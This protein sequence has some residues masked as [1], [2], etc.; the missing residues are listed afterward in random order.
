MQGKYKSKEKR[1]Q[2]KGRCWLCFNKEIA[3]MP[4][5]RPQ[6][7]VNKIDK[8]KEITSKIWIGTSTEPLKRN[9]TIETFIGLT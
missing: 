5:N 7:A 8:T 2:R 1:K 3:L 4:N 6:I 9:K